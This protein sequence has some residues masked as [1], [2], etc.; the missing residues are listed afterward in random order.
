[1]I[2]KYEKPS[3]INSSSSPKKLQRENINVI[4]MFKKSL[5]IPKAKTPTRKP[6]VIG[7]YKNFDNASPNFLEI[8]AKIA[9]HPS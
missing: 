6:T 9:F 8:I 7:R 4:N 2:F 1:M 3:S 5:N